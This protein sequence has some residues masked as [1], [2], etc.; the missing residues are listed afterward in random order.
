MKKKIL[1]GLVIIFIIVASIMY[2]NNRKV[3]PGDLEA[4]FK[5]NMAVETFNPK[6]GY[7][8]RVFYEVFLRS[9]ADSNGDGVGDLKG[10]TG[11][12][13]YLKDLG[14]R[15]IW[16]TPINTS[17]SYHGYDITNYYDINPDYG[18]MEDFQ[19][20]IKECHKRDILVS[21][22]L[23]LN[24]TS[25]YHPWFRASKEDKNS[26]YRDYYVWSDKNTNAN[27]KSSIDTKPWVKL[28]LLG[29]QYYYAMFN[30][31]MPDLNYDNPE[32]RQNAKDIAKF[33]LNIG[34][35][36][37]RLDAA[38]HIY[39]K[40]TDK[41]LAWWKEFNDYVKSQNKNAVLT[42]EVWDKPETVSTYMK[43]LDTCFDFEV[44][45]AIIKS[46]YKNDLSNLSTQI[47]G[48]YNVYSEKNKSFLDSPFLTNH[49]MPRV[50]SRL[51]NVENITADP[52]E[53]AKK[54]A[55]IL[56]TLPGTP[57]VYYGEET[58]M[59]GNKPDEQIREPFIWDNK[60]RKKNTSWENSINHV[61]NIAVSVE[62]KNP[63]SMLNF[64]KRI[65]NIRNSSEILKYGRF[66]TVNVKNSN[67]LAYK[68]ILREKQ[69]YVFINGV[70]SVVSEDIDL[71]GAKVLYS[72]KRSDKVLGKN[73][74]VQ[75][76]EILIFEK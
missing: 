17:T 74:E 52:T 13:D 75:G 11:K 28:R 29:N 55:A 27:E 19:E 32:V 40:E 18:T 36:G 59:R 7:N 16:L 76:D 38:R 24:H 63:E 67:L 33:Y 12:L 4:T 43:S 54:A 60:D 70:S 72:N 61:D 64:Y 62:E 3:K 25:A 66:E 10:L 68:R 39:D 47:N 14:I 26:K 73:L 41:N 50:M 42:G 51:Q 44:G 9:F 2:S 48:V 69:V 21:M 46:L 45:E 30:G 8:G 6:E 65:I 49:D 58:G 37:F 5:T 20:L 15:G 1:Y 35:D 22:D 31:M 23:V 57:Y 53:K 34:I 71:S 56:L